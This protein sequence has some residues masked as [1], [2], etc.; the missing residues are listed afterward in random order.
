MV[1]VLKLKI[2]A[3]VRSLLHTADVEVGHRMKVQ[4]KV[5]VQVLELRIAAAAVVHS[6]I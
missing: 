2:M 3:L 6:Y 1:K 4:E 5:Q